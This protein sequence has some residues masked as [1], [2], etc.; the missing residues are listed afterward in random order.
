M[1]KQSYCYVC[2]KV[3]RSWITCT[4][5]GALELTEVLQNISWI[6]DRKMRTTS[7]CTACANAYYREKTPLRELIYVP[8]LRQVEISSTNEQEV[9]PSSSNEDCLGK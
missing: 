6:K 4:I 7:L 1:T 9:H 3:T 8:P 2:R 5:P